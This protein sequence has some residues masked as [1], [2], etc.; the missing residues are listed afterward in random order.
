MPTKAFRWLARTSYHFP[1]CL[2]N[3]HYL[4][5]ETDLLKDHKRRYFNIL[6]KK[7]SKV[8]VLVMDVPS[9]IVQLK[10]LN[11][12]EKYIIPAKYKRPILDEL[13]KLGI[14]YSFIYPEDH[15]KKAEMIKDKYLGL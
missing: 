5:A 7:S 1:I 4:S 12:K 14:D 10:F 9:K 6:L 11:E 13:A 8:V 3:T 2:E 15:T